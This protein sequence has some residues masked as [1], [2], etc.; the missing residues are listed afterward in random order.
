MPT[1]TYTILCKFL[2][3]LL[4]GVTFEESTEIGL[5]VGEDG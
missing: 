1:D 3:R 4:T 2:E 5:G